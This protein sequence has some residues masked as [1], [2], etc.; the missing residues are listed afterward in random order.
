MNRSVCFRPSIPTVAK[1]RRSGK[2]FSSIPAVIF[3]DQGGIVIGDGSLIGHNVTLATLNH[4][5]APQQRQS[6]YPAP[7]V[8]GRN[9][10]IGAGVT[11]VPGITIGNNAVVG[12]G[13]VVTKNVPANTVVAGIPAKGLKPSNRICKPRTAPHAQKKRACLRALF[14]NYRIYPERKTDSNPRPSAWEADALPTELF[15]QI[16]RSL[17]YIV[18]Q[19]SVFP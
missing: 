10:W 8:I 1:I 19:I 14:C 18:V 15:P 9:V 3:Q 5:M 11:V 12:A 7:I 16:C 17:P 13:S 4:G 2:M 6:L